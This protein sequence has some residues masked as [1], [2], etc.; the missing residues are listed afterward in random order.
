MTADPPDAAFGGSLPGAPKAVTVSKHSQT[1][2]ALIVSCL[3]NKG[4]THV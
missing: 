2:A 1:V 3:E 4:V